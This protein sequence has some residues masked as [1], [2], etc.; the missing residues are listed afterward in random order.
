MSMSHLKF[1]DFSVTHKSIFA[2][3]QLRWLLN[4]VLLKF[5]NM[6]IPFLP[7]PLA[8]IYFGTSF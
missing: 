3:A 4:F 8:L 6:E 1:K 7:I 2:S 5:Q